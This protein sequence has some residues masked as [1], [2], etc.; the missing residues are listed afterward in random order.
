[1]WVLFRVVVER[2]HSVEWFGEEL[3]LF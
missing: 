2:E 1:V 3:F